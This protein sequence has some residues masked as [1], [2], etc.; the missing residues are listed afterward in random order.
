LPQPVIAAR[1]CSLS[2]LGRFLGVEI[3]TLEQYPTNIAKHSK[4]AVAV[5]TLKNRK[6]MLMRCNKLIYRLQLKA[7]SL[8]RP[9]NAAAH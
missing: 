2:G 5:R 9:T 6:R 3:E 7:Y 1:M 4:F 8:A